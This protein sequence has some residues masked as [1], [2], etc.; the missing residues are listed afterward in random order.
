METIVAYSDCIEVVSDASEL[1]EITYANEKDFAGIIYDPDKPQ[2]SILLKAK[3]YHERYPEENESTNLS[4]NS[5]VKLS[6]QV[7]TQ[8]LFQTEPMPYFMHEKLKLIF[9]HNYIS[10]DGQTWEKEEAYEVEQMHPKSPFA[11]GEV[12]LTKKTDSVFINVFGE[13]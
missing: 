9:Q 7:K 5:V 8:R 6:G 12:W 3:F 1:M 4:D 13:V 11:K 2:F 10:I